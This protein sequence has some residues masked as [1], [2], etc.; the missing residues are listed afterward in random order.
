MRRSAYFKR[1][2]LRNLGDKSSHGYL[3]SDP[4]TFDYILKYIRRGIFPL[5]FTAERGHDYKAYA[6][7]L[8]QA[9]VSQCPILIWKR[10][11]I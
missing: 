7:L 6:E 10:M 3:D 9:R 5:L 4:K 11:T 2:F 1:L 8:E